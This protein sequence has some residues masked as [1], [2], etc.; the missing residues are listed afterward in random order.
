MDGLTVAARQPQNL[1]GVADRGE[2]ITQLMDQHRQELVL[3]FCGFAHGFRRAHCL[4]RFLALGHGLDAE[5]NSPGLIADVV[6]PA[7][8][9]G[10]ALSFTGLFARF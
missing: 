4:L 9:L 1:Q 3:A 10:S 6:Q 5:E 8:L 2:R 7:L